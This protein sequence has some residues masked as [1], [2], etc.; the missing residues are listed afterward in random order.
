VDA[1]APSAIPDR[2]VGAVLV[3]VT[4]DFGRNGGTLRL[5]PTPDRLG[6]ALRWSPPEAGDKVRQATAF[7]PL[8]PGGRF[9]VSY[10]GGF[11]LDV[12]VI[13][14]VT[15]RRAAA[16]TTGLFVPA[17]RPGA[18][19]ARIRGGTR[20]PLDPGTA[21]PDAGAALLTVTARGP[22]RGRV[23]VAEGPRPSR[24]VLVSPGAGVPRSALVPVLGGSDLSIGAER[25]TAVRVD[26]VGVYL[27][28]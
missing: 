24:A 10:H 4:A 17:P 25:D 20:T 28:H 19:S 18:L 13:A 2:G 16:A 26:T 5:A 8:G 21:V 1:L 9:A 7:V 11:V 27:A 6:P 23:D 3:Q 15:D 12:D 14:F 22:D